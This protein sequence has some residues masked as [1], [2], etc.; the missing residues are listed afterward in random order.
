MARVHL[1]GSA[2]GPKSGHVC[3]ELFCVQSLGAAAHWSR[4]AADAVF[5]SSRQRTLSGRGEAFGEE[6]QG[7]MGLND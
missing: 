6:A 1:G 7:L 5:F 3:P 4:A 2:G